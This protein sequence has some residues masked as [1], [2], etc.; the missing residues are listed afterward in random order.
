MRANTLTGAG[1]TAQGTFVELRDNVVNG[2]PGTG[3]LGR[4]LAKRVLRPLR[5]IPSRRCGAVGEG[6]GSV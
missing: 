2:C 6:R 4:A 3:L 1:L 5:L